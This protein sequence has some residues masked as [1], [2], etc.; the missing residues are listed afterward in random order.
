DGIALD[1]DTIPT[2][3][4][5][6]VGPNEELLQAVTIHAGC[7]VEWFFHAGTVRVAATLLMFLFLNVSRIVLVG[8]VVK[9][10]WG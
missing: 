2:C 1:C 6:C 3:R 4:M 9:L 5:T 7:M 8:G 10:N